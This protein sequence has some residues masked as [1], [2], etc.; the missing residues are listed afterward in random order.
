VQVD[1]RLN[2]DGTGEKSLLKVHDTL[3]GSAVLML[4]VLPI[5]PFHVIC[6]L[7][8]TSICVCFVSCFHRDSSCIFAGVT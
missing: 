7:W 5:N 8:V 6:L 4:H 3:S 2:G 1:S